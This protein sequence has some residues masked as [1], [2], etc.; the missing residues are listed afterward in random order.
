MASGATT[1]IVALLF[2]HKNPEGLLAIVT[3]GTGFTVTVN[4]PS[5]AVQPV[6]MSVTVTV[7]LWVPTGSRLPLSSLNS[8]SSPVSP[9][10]Q[11]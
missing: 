9:F 10:D 2:S 11:V 6:T 7:K 8:I 5:V 3:V 4:G 1:L